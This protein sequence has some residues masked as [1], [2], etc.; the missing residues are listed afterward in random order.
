MAIRPLHWL[1]LFALVLLW[2]SSYL[3][4]E[5]ALVRWRPEQLTGLRITL[6]A[7]VLAAC[8]VIRRDRYPWRPA[9]WGYLLLIAIIGNCLLFF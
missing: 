4:I 5:L 8:I 7:F 2:G 3:L 1:A 6:A 9:V